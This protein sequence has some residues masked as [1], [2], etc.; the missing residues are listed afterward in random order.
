VADPAVYNAILE[1]NKV[2]QESIQTVGLQVALA[3]LSSCPTDTSNWS[4]LPLLADPVGYF[5][6]GEQAQAQLTACAAQAK[7]SEAR[8]HLLLQLLMYLQGMLMYCVQAVHIVVMLTAR[9]LT[10]LLAV[11]AM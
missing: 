11:L 6:Y 4:L 8:E 7:H 3:A 10:T 2:L 5:K 9:V 1:E